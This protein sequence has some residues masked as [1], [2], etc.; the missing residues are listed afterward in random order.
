MDTGATLI[1]VGTGVAGAIGLGTLILAVTP[2]RI[3]WKKSTDP[4]KTRRR[5]AG[6]VWLVVC[7][8]LVAGGAGL[9]A[10]NANPQS[11]TRPPVQT[12]S[13]A[14]VQITYPQDVQ[15]QQ[16]PTVGCV[17]NVT[18]KGA[19]PTGDVLVLGSVKSG[20]D[21]Q[22]PLQ[23]D[24]Q[25]SSETSWHATVYFGNAS[26]ANHIFDLKAVVMPEAWKDYLLNEALYYDAQSGET[27]WSSGEPPAPA[28]VEAS[29]AV[30]RMPV[31]H[32]QCQ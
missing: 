31:P 21:E 25:W 14:A 24:V 8:V 18:G 32:G 10:A 26:D 13:A 6:T 3:E 20:G 23:D 28:Q 22:L 5:Q 1:Y 19:V 9:A 12:S 16:L 30:M 7:G 15:G 29:V 27:W 4:A 11:T 2:W 17:V